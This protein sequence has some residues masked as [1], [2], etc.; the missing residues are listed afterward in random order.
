MFLSRLAAYLLENWS[1]LLVNLWSPIFS[2]LNIPINRN[3]A[4]ISTIA[5]LLFLMGFTFR[6]RGTSDMASPRWAPVLCCVA[7]ITF[8]LVYLG[9]LYLRIEF[10]KT[11]ALDFFAL[12][13]LIGV[14]FF[15]I[16]ISI[17]ILLFRKFSVALAILVSL[18][19]LD[20]GA[21]VIERVMTIGNGT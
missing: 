18:I 19:L 1:L 5:V 11:I 17:Q 20:K 21:W 15:A 9:S 6:S 10:E 2:L 12:L 7:N 13:F 4:E 14:L 8:G 16:F 3:L